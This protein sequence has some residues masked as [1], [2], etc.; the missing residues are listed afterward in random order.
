MIQF[1]MKCLNFKQC[2][3]TYIH[4]R[5]QGASPVNKSHLCD[6]CLN[7]PKPKPEPKPEVKPDYMKPAESKFF[8]KVSKKKA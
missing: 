3:G 6:K 1:E 5:G 4:E 8:G 2:G 7:P